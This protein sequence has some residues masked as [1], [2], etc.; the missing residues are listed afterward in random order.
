MPTLV[1]YEYRRD[2]GSPIDVGDVLNFTVDSLTPD[3]EYSFEVRAVYDDD[4]RGPWSNVATA[5]TISDWTPNEIVSAWA[6]YESDSYAQD[7]DSSVLVPWQ[8]KSPNNRDADPSGPILYHLNEI[9]GLPSVGLDG[10]GGYFAIPSMAALTAGAYYL[11]LKLI[12]A[13]TSGG[14]LFGTSGAS[15]YPYGPDGL[16]YDCFGSNVRKNGITSNISLANTWH[17]VHGYSKPNDWAMY[18]NRTLI[19]ATSSNT[20]SF[21]GSPS[22]GF[23]GSQYMRAHVAGLYLFSDKPSDADEDMLFEYFA[24]KWGV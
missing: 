3:T 5:T 7:D 2:G 6:W 19:R 20:V 10:G 11:V 4:S 17:V 12:D 13:T 16:I 21:S 9:N 22:L 1:S 18:Q 24:S 8:D 14:N 23:N 15:H